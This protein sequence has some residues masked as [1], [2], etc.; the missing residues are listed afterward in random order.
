MPHYKVTDIFSKLK[1]FSKPNPP[2]P[3]AVWQDPRYFVAFGFGS[4]TISTAPGTMGTIMAIPFYLLLRPLPLYLY[5]IF[6][7]CFI[8]ASA[9]LCEKLSRDTHTHDHPGMNI[10]EFAGFFVT[11]INAPW[12]WPWILL[13]FLLF[14]IFDVLKP[15]PISY[16]D[17]KMTSGLGMILDDV[18][19]GLF[20]FILIQL[21][22]VLLGRHIL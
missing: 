9:W 18:V 19:A 7:I 10:D 13:G 17:K 22:A 6:V 20:G 14:R 16:I 21:F 4:G 2:V 11:M 8:A 1:T 5:I 15:W 12:G 3:A